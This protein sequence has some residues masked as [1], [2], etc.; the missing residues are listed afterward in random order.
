MPLSGWTGSRAAILES[1]ATLLDQLDEYPTLRD[2]VAQEKERLQEWI[3]E[4]RGRE[5]ASDR[6]RDERFE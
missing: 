4:E 1:N 2:A 5:T 6:A 3:K